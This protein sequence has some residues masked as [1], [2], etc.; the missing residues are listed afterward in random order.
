[1]QRAPQAKQQIAGLLQ[2]AAG[3]GRQLLGQLQKELANDE[4]FAGIAAMLQQWLGNEGDSSAPPD[5]VEAAEPSESLVTAPSID[6]SRQLQ[7]A[8]DWQ[9]AIAAYEA[10][11]ENEPDNAVAWF[12]VAYCLHMSGAYEKAISAHQ[13]AATFEQFKGVS[14]YN[15]AC[16]YALTGRSSKAM[17]ALEE[18]RAAGFDL[19]DPLRSDSDLDSL[20]G[21]PRF[22]EF[23]ADIG[24]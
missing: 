10:V 1:M 9:A 4:R 22:E 3:R 6:V 7:Q 17:K 2:M 8:G 23:L 13:E 11:I 20:R 18:S 24:G 16:A 15:L 14:L 5:E 19:A 12:G 21:D